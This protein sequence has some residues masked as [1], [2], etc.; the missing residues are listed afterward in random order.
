M[1]S[2]TISEQ[3]SSTHVVFRATLYRPSIEVHRKEWKR[4]KGRFV[5]QTIVI[6][7]KMVLLITVR[8]LEKSLDR[9]TTIN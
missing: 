8:K 6:M 4:P 9:L 7:Y 3:W 2:C 1:V 5:F